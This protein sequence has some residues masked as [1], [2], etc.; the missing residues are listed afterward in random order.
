MNRLIRIVNSFLVFNFLPEESRTAETQLCIKPRPEQSRVGLF[1][2]SLNYT[3]LQIHVE[4]FYPVDLLT[5]SSSLSKP[6]LH[7]LYMQFSVFRCLI[8][9]LDWII[10]LYELNTKPYL[11]ICPVGCLSQVAT[12]M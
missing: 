5:G 6:I 9:H 10:R 11:A 7:C 12:I 8:R 4:T 1:V 2:A 3:K